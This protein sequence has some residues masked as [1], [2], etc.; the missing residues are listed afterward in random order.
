M[1]DNQVNRKRKHE[2]LSAH[3]AKL[4]SLNDSTH[5][6]TSTSSSP[7]LQQTQELPSQQL[8]SEPKSEKKV[9]T[10]NKKTKL[11][12]SRSSSQPTHYFKSHQ[13][14]YQTLLKQHYPGFQVCHDSVE[15]D[16]QTPIHLAVLWAE[17]WFW[18]HIINVDNFYVPTRVSRAFVGEWG[19][20]MKYINIHTQM[21]IHKSFSKHE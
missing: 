15:L 13:K 19:M 6:S 4:R 18:Q 3:W 10:N 8:L 11:S 2:L 1:N 20:T 9:N 5:T 7:S 12:P 21:T 14:E 17:G 16:K